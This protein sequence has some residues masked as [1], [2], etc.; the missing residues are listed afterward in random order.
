MTVCCHFPPYKSTYEN[1]FLVECEC[2]QCSI[3]FCNTG[4]ASYFLILHNIARYDNTAKSE[5]MKQQLKPTVP[6]WGSMNELD[7]CGVWTT[8]ATPGFFHL[9]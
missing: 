3:S 8:N 2:L 7:Y 4:T 9:N 1:V 6:S 5:F